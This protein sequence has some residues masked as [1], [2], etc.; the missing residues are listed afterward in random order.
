MSAPM[1]NIN[2]SPLKLF[3]IT[4][5]FGV[6]AYLC[7]TYANI[8]HENMGMRLLAFFV[9][10]FG[11]FAY[12][13]FN[14][15]IFSLLIISLSQSRF[16]GYFVRLLS[17]CWSPFIFFFQYGLNKINNY[18]D[19]QRLYRS[20]IEPRAAMNVLMFLTGFYAT[21]P[22][23]AI[24]YLVDQFY[25]NGYLM[26]TFF[27]AGFFLH[28]FGLKMIRNIVIQKIQSYKE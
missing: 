15:G 14:F 7:L 10:F 22:V 9:I 24:W 3:W 13:A 6:F 27:V 19:L 11:G 12:F 18:N 4:L 21:L 28:E 25:M 2:R 8:E 17:L 16:K 23:F 5:L 1:K 26:V 20:L